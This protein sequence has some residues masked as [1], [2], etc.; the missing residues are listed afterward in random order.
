[1]REYLGKKKCGVTI[2]EILGGAT[3]AVRLRFHKWE[4]NLAVATA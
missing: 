3:P 1:M 4:T 2:N